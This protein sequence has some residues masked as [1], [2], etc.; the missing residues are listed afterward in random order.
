MMSRRQ[1]RAA[2]TVSP[3]LRPQKRAAQATRESHKAKRSK[4][5]L[6]TTVPNTDSRQP[7]SE[8]PSQLATVPIVGNDACSP[9]PSGHRCHSLRS[10][11]RRTYSGRHTS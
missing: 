10:R 5:A 8:H 3:A 7:T 2:P 11:A 1:S 9:C 4:S 6:R